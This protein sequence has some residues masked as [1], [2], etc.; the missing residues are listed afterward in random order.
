[1]RGLLVR[2]GVLI[3]FLTGVHGL[4]DAQRPPVPSKPSMKEPMDSVSIRSKWVPK[5]ANDRLQDMEDATKA[6][7]QDFLEGKVSL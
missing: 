1:M 5:S 3:V 4:A 2:I 6:K 7:N